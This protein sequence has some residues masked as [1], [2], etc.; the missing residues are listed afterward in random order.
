[1]NEFA[2]HMQAFQGPSRQAK[3]QAALMLRTVLNECITREA[4]LCVVGLI[5][6]LFE[7]DDIAAELRDLADAIEHGDL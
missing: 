5:C 7:P 3:L 4:R 1:M 2:D 6:K